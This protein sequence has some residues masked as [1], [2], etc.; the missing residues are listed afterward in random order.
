MNAI[1]VLGIGPGSGDFIAPA[2]KRIIEESEVVIG[3]AR[4]LASFDLNDKETIEI[5][6]DLEAIVRYLKDNYTK[7]RISVIA[8][9]DPGFY[10]ILNYLKR[11][12]T[13]DILRC[14]PGISSIQYMFAKINMTCDDA[15]LGSLH[16]RN[17]AII[18][19][20]RAYSKAAFLTD[21]EYSYQRIAALLQ[22]NGFGDR[23]MYV[24]GNLSYNDEE[25]IIDK[26][27]HL[28]NRDKK[29]TLCV[30]IIADE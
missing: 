1:H 28:I 30:V 26:A 10:G 24:G 21:R 25:I 12:F 18:E 17:D 22:K 8:S 6:G 11:H 27:K 7:K 16:G 2:V 14:V 23:T 4:N 9:G 29:F 3:G 15:Y 20:I 5:R 13:S 19:K